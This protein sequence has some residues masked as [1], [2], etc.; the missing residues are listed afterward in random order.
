MVDFH[1]SCSVGTSFL[2]SLL[3]LTA[4]MA[5]TQQV[6]GPVPAAF[7][8]TAGSLLPHIHTTPATVRT[9]QVHGA[10]L[11]TLHLTAFLLLS[12]HP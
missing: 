1:L 5:R 8:L 11:V 7:R 2:D 12:W 4:A 3:H 6:H 10:A 9:P